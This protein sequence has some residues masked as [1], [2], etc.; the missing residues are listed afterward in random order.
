MTAPPLTLTLAHSPDPD[1]AFMWWP[2]GDIATGAEPRIDTKGFW[3][4]TVA[5]DIETL[6]R[7]AVEGL[8]GGG[9]LDITAMSFH[10]WAHCADRYA[11]TRCGASFGDGYGPKIVARAPIGP[12]RLRD[13]ALVIATPGD[14]TTASLVMRLMLSDAAPRT[15]AMPFHRIVEAVRAGE[16]DAGIVIHEAQLTFADAGLHL[17]V[18]LG[19]WWHSET[20]LPLPLGANAIRRDIDARFGPGTMVRVAGVLRDS[21]AY[22]RAHRADGLAIAGG[23]AQPGTTA[24]QA[25]RFVAMYV[26][27]LTLDAGQRGERAVAELMRRAADAGLVPRGVDAA[28]VG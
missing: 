19:A 10:A 1:D 4:R 18:D 11:V 15:I 26:N 5:E 27:D 22:A 24:D 14:R 21:I 6:N 3:F 23:F 2:L 28:M 20:G 16:V 12:A 8:G 13:P 9:D 17:V 7:R 25:D